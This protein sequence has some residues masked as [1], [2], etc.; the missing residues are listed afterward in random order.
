M[1]KCPTCG[2]V[3]AQNDDVCGVCGTSLAEVTASSDIASSTDHPSIR[4]ALSSE[5][6]RRANRRIKG[7]LG[8]LAGISI[9]ATAILVI[10]F[11]ALF[12]FL[13]LLFG[14]TVI[15]TDISWM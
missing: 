1:K 3:N 2:A 9:V 12:G 5:K 8:L 4:P 7:I 15:A 11:I 14:F 13:I 6:A 10:E